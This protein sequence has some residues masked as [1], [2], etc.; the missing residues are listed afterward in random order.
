MGIQDLMLK[1]P[2]LNAA[3]M[4]GFA[5]PSHW[6]L[7]LPPGAFITHPISLKPR[8]P[9]ENRTVLQFAGG[10]LLHTGLPNPG[11]FATLKQFARR[12]ARSPLPVWVHIIPSSPAEAAQMVAHLENIEGVTA[13]ELGLPPGLTDDE[14][15]RMIEAA[16]GELPLLVSL[17]VDRYRE[18]WVFQTG[19]SPVSGLILS[20]PRGV[21]FRTDRTLVEGRLYGP[22]LFPQ[23][24]AA[25]HALRSTGLP[26]IVGCGLYRHA[27]V[28][29]VLAS[30]ALAVQFDGALWK[31]LLP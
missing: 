13:I 3:S 31:G 2:Y 14:N 28:E 10:F 6:P 17:P 15:L 18:A 11:L 8:A 27:D 26:L 21:L 1:S 19:K 20:A 25:F 4:F 16:C 7:D 30:G 5:P 24:L 22:A 23:M 12:W 9:A 29:A